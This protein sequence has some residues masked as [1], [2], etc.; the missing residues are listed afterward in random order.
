MT[1]HESR[2]HPPAAACPLYAFPSHYQIVSG[3]RMHYLDEGRGRPVVLLHG[4]PTWSFLYRDYIPALS[5]E[6]RVLAVDHIGCGLSDKPTEDRYPFTLERRITDLESLLSALVPGEKLSLAVHD[7]G[8][9]I[10]FGYAVRHPDRIRQVVV[11]NSAAFA[12]PREKKF[13]LILRICRK[14]RAAGS[15]IRSLNAFAWPASYLMCKKQR[16]SSTIRRG[17]LAPYNSRANRAAI[18]RFIRDI[19]LEP[20]HISYRVMSDIQQKLY[21]LRD[22]PMI[23][24]WGGR[25]FIFDRRICEEWSR[26]FP[27]ARVHMFPEAGHNVVEDEKDAILPLLREFLASGSRA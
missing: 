12:W 6:Y 15:L 8:G 7:W 19:P 20:D 27:N 24:F 14:S 25:D 22:V 3:H 16:M 1:P 2:G 11:F 10:G 17:Y 23:I 26:F 18:H 4:N 5:N 21:L 9:P 13:P